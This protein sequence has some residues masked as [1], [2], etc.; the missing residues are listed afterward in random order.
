MIQANDCT[1]ALMI[2]AS[3]AMQGMKRYEIAEA[4]GEA[5]RTRHIRMRSNE[6]FFLVRVAIAAYDATLCYPRGGRPRAA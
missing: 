3:G 1:E 6:Y 2:G 4:I 5:C